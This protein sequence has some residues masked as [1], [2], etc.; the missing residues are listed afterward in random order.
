MKSIYC[1]FVVLLLVCVGCSGSR[2]YEDAPTLTSISFV[3]RNGFSETVSSVDRLEKY[4]DADFL[5]NQPYQRVLRVYERDDEGDIAAFVSS[6]HSNGQPKQYLEVVNGRAFGKYQEWY[7]NGNLKLDAN[8]IGGIADINLAAEQSWLFDGCNKAWNEEGNLQAEINYEKGEMQGISF[9]YHANGAVWKKIPYDKNLIDGTVE[10]Y[11]ESGELL[12]TGE[13]SQGTR[14]GVSVRYWGPGKIASQETFVNGLLQSGVYYS[15]SGEKVAEVK[16]GSGVRAL[17][18][19]SYIS[20]LQEYREGIPGGEIKVYDSAGKMVRIYHIKSNLKH[21]EEIE[22]YVNPLLSTNSLKPKISI[23]WYEGKIQG[24]VKT[25]YDNGAME[26][27]REMSKNAKNGL[28]TSWYR[29]GNLM[30][31]E[32]Y[33]N[34]KLVKG[35]YFKKGERSPVSQIQEG[36]GVATLFDAEGNFVRKANYAKGRPLE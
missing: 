9:H 5:N 27:Q 18:G 24:M 13:Y 15:L 30:L 21:G 35:E 2:Q 4:S 3:D 31:I 14:H 19:K 22:Y 26:S 33:D 1:L 7:Q 29:D 25:W 8:V 28:L 6:Y 12:M 32:E 36:K 16:N 11:L 34:D 20:E 23:N 10:I 17:F